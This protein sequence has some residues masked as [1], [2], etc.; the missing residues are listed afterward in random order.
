MEIIVL[1]KPIPDLQKIKISRGQGQIFETGKQL[2]NSYDRV[3]LQLAVN[4]KQKYG[5]RI[6]VVSICD[7]TKT[8]ILREAYAMGVDVCFNLWEESFAAND[9][10]V[11]TKL[12]GEAIKK[13]SDFDLIICGA[14]SDS[15][16]GGQ[17]GPRLAE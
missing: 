7:I 15:G 13:I 12:L 1:I 5:G 11:N 9:A 16:F 3:G 8:D 6:A 14:K 4:L 10:F 2:M 17:T